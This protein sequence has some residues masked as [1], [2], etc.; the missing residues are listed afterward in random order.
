MFSLR[1]SVANA[2]DL[3]AELQAIAL[4]ATRPGVSYRLDLCIVFVAIQVY[5]N[6]A[7]SCS[8]IAGCA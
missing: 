8:G 1:L 5:C 7:A 3:K 2:F 4:L 6:L